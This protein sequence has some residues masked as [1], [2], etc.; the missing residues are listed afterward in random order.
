MI[1]LGTNLD[2]GE[3]VYLAPSVFDLHTQ[4]R[5]MT[6][7]GKTILQALVL[8]SYLTTGRP[9]LIIDLAGDL[10]LWNLLKEECDSRGRNFQTVS[11]DVQEDTLA[12]N[13][14]QGFDTTGNDSVRNAVTLVQGLGLDYGAGYG[15]G[16]FSAQNVEIALKAFESLSAP[17]RPPFQLTELAE[18]VTRM[19]KRKRGEAS[20]LSLALELLA[21]Y[22]K[23]D[24]EAGDGLDIA[25]GIESNSVMYFFIDTL[26][27]GPAKSVGSFAAFS[28]IMGMMRRKRE[29]KSHRKL[30]IAIDEF[31]SVAKVSGFIEAIPQMLKFDS[32]FLLVHQSESQLATNRDE[33]LSNI[34]R[35]NCSTRI[36]L[37]CVGD[38][39]VSLQRESKSSTTT[40]KSRTESGFFN[41]SV[42]HRDVE[43]YELKLNKIK[44][45]S[46]TAFQGFL[47]HRDGKGFVNPIP[48]QFRPPPIDEY[49]RLSK[50]PIPRSQRAAFQTQSNST[51]DPAWVTKIREAIA[52]AE[53]LENWRNARVP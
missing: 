33:T 20:E 12:F 42:T 8:V 19:S 21:A 7:S 52:R 36:Y 3:A 26:F 46:S 37:T 48:F 45:V 4:I 49:A 9:L 6:R 44:E 13:P 30:L 14:L 41:S 39:E 10:Y 32:S 23:L 28:A 43:D 17:S 2:T 1:E 16:F 31:A 34:V 47:M 50:Q 40:Q 51:P 25:N 22:P 38:D 35:E 27:Q 11:M 15:K 53:S 18:T 29:G 5:G 24:V